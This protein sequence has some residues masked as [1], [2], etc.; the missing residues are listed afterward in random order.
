M[1]LSKTL[2]SLVATAA[3]L[4]ALTAATDARADAEFTV[5]G[6]SGT[7]EV[8]GNGHWHINKDAP[9]KATV[10]GTTF[11]KDKWTL[12]DAS[13]KVSGVPKGDATVKVYVCNGDQCK[14]AEVKV[15]VK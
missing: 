14:N 15:A 8:K 6:G 11:A 5:T 13:A 4:V 12:S 10:G 2:G 9:W 3:A 7:I 1:R